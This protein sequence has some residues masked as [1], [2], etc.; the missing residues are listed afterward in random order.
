MNQKTHDSKLYTAYHDTTKNEMVI[1]KKIF[2]ADVDVLNKEYENYKF[3]YN[4]T[5]HVFDTQTYT[6][7]MSSVIYNGASLTVNNPIFY[8]NPSADTG[9]FKVK[10]NT[11][12]CYFESPIID[13][14]YSD[15]G[16]T[17]FRMRNEATGD[18]VL[19]M[20]QK[21]LI[22]DFNYIFTQS[23]QSDKTTMEMKVNM[24]KGA[25]YQV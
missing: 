24:T 14:S 11:G 8:F 23:N 13:Q 15:S 9:Y 10:T 21:T 18:N 16:N 1:S 20:Q 25:P 17:M 5:N 7:S 2:I 19:T 6:N 3:T 12:S 22:S 4:K